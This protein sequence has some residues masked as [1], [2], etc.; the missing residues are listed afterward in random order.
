MFTCILHIRLWC[1]VYPCLHHHTP[2]SKNNPGPINLSC[3]F[4]MVGVHQ[5]NQPIVYTSPLFYQYMVCEDHEVIG[6]DCW[7]LQSSNGNVHKGEERQHIAPKTI[8]H[9]YKAV[10]SVKWVSSITGKVVGHLSISSLSSLSPGG[11]TI[12]QRRQTKSFIMLFFRWIWQN[13]L[14][15]FWDSYGMGVIL[16]ITV[17]GLL[18]FHLCLHLLHAIAELSYW[19]NSKPSSQILPSSIHY[20]SLWVP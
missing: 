13:S 11:L 4:V 1:H 10:V 8:Q 12:H 19:R 16:L 15:L 3:S 2:Q 14:M 6:H 17:L 18:P 7:F 9:L 5:F 20:S